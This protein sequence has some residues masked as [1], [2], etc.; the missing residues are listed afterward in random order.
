MPLIMLLVFYAVFALALLILAAAQKP[1]ASR[2]T[3]ATLFSALKLSRF[4]SDEIV[5]IQKEHRLSTIPWLYDLLSG[6]SVILELHKTLLQ[7]GLIASPAKLVMFSIL[8]WIGSASLIHWRMY[9]GFAALAPALL[10]G[11]LPLVYVLRKRRKRLNQMQEKLAEALDLMV[12]ALRAGHSMGGALAAASK[13]APEPIGRELRLCSEEINFGIDLRTAMGDLLDRVPLQDLRLMAT[14][15]LIH[16]ESSGN[17]AEVLEKT[18][19]VVRDRSR[20]RQQIRVHTAQGRVSGAVLVL[21]PIALGIVLD[22]VNPA[23]MHTLVCGP[24]GAANPGRST[25]HESGRAVRHPENR[26]YPDMRS[27]WDTP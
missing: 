20:L 11:A 1:S 25:S 26:E 10:A 7:A 17:L 21:L 13:E 4:G 22:L 18:A 23:Y 2:Q 19:S 27:S 15:M 3:H 8:V 16:K 24:A 9:L 14:A 12:S 5:D 6:I